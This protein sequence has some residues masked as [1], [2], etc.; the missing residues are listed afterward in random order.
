MQRSRRQILAAFTALP[1]LAP[2]VVRAQPAL[3]TIR[4]G[5][6][7]SETATPLAYAI[8]AGLFERAG[9][10]IEL[11]KLTSGGAAAVAVASGALDVGLTSLL[12]VVVGHARGIPFTIV[13]PSGIRLPTSDGGLLV[14]STSA[15][16]TAKDFIGKTISTAALD[17]IVALSMFA[18]LDQNGVDPKSVKF[19]EIP[20][21][22]ALAALEQGRVDGV[23]LTNPAFT[24][25][26]A[27]GKTR[28]VANIFIAIASRY[29][30]GAW[31][32]TS[33][34]VEK[35]RTTA[36]Q[37]ARVLGDASSY[38][39][40]HA[41][42]TIDDLVETTGVDR[43]FAVRMKRTVLTPTVVAAEIQPV[44]DAAA[45]Y[46]FLEKSYPAAELVSDTALKP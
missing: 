5:S 19:V 17:D 3:T 40:T 46:K 22:A 20:Q 28:L 14:A 26:L 39:N 12:T 4:V 43:S 44:I 33:G 35:N 34:W 25:A 6:L 10:R 13:A 36:Q 21:L 31:F 7:R 8:R 41:N 11:S 2:A 32:S 38:V 42:E 18:W 30:L 37:F 29:L 1:V 16:R 24:V 23:S 27:G 9:L 15:L 45:K